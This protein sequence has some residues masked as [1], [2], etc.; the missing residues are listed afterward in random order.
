MTVSAYTPNSRFKLIDF[1]SANWHTDEWSNWQLLD[2]LMEAEFGDIPFAVAAGSANAITLDYTVNQTVATGLLLSFRATANN[3]GAMTI[4]VD[5]AAA[6]SLKVLGGDAIADD[7]VANTYI[8]VVFDG[9]NFVLIEPISRFNR[10]TVNGPITIDATLTSGLGVLTPNNVTAYINFGDPED[11]DVGRITFNHNNNLMSFVAPGGYDFDVTQNAGLRLNNS[12][13]TDFQIVEQLTNGIICLGKVTSD[14]G[15]FFNLANNRLGFNVP[16]PGVD[17][18]FNGDM[19]VT[20]NAIITGTVTVGAIA[21]SSLTGQVAVAN[22][23]TGANNAIN[24]R[25]NLGL[26]SIAVLSTINGSNWSG[27]DL[28]IADGGTGASTAGAAFNN[29]AASG[30]TIGA[31]LTFTAKGVVPFFNSAAM[32]SGE[33]FVQAIGADPTANPGDIVFE[34]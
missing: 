17:F 8:R 16:S 30:G 4:A 33:M 14:K 18:D 21:A 29:I 1:N 10:L 13:A 34:Y 26:G 2:A 25:T 3:T 15:I 6:K 27:S 12:T 24:A 11:A 9:T 31:R 19:I 20:G 32:T 7:I 5:G 28:A 22:G 23:G